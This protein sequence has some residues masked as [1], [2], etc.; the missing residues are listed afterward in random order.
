MD[1]R[2]RKKKTFF[3]YFNIEIYQKR[4]SSQEFSYGSR[5][6]C[7]KIFCKYELKIMFEFWQIFENEKYVWILTEGF[8]QIT[9]QYSRN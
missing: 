7:S 3:L 9:S 8:Y 6:P 4:A 2:E 1:G 5:R